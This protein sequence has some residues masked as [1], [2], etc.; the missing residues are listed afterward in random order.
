MNFIDK[1]FSAQLFV[2]TAAIKGFMANQVLRI[3]G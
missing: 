2:K 3:L 1:G